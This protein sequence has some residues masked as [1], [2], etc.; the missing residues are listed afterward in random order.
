MTRILDGMQELRD[1]MGGLE[2]ALAVMAPAM[3]T[4]Y[5]I[6]KLKTAMET[7]F[8]AMSKRLDAIEESVQSLQDGWRVV[9]PDEDDASGIGGATTEWEVDWNEWHSRPWGWHGC[10]SRRSPQGDGARVSP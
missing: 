3:A 2:A 10:R 6:G 8:D 4:K 7:R 5:D 9:V 1:G